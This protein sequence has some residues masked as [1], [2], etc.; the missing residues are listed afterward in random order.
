ATGD[1]VGYSITNEIYDSFGEADV[2]VTFDGDSAAERGERFLTDDFLEALSTE[3]ADDPEIDGVTGVLNEVLP[4]LN[5]EARLVEADATLIGVDPQ[6][7]DAF[8]GLRSLDGDLIAGS[9]LGGFR[10]YLSEELAEAIDAGPGDGV[11]VYYDG[12][13]TTFE[14]IGIVQN[15]SIT[16]SQGRGGLVASLDV[17]REVTG[18]EGKLSVIIV[19]IT[20][21]VRDTLDRND[22]VADRVEDFIAANPE[23]Q[24]EIFFTK[25]EAVELAELIGSIFVTFFLIFGLFAIASGIL[26]IFMIFVMLAAERR[27]EMG[28]ARAV[29]MQRLHLTESFLAEGMAYN[30]GSAAVGALLGL[31]VAFLLVL[32]LAQIFSDALGFG[33]TFNFNWQGFLVAY[34]LGVVLTFATVA[35]SSFR[36][37]NL[38]IVRAIRDLPEPQPLRGADRSIGGLFR[39]AL[40][41]LWMIGWIVVLVVSG[42]FTIL[43][44]VLSIVGVF[45]NLPLILEAIFG[46]AAL[47]AVGALMF[48]GARTVRRGQF[49]GM[50]GWRNWLIWALWVA[51]FNVVAAG[52]WLLQLSRDWAGRHRNAGGWAVI[53][54]LIGVTFVWLSGWGIDAL[55]AFQGQAF[56]YTGGFTLAVLA[57]AM[58]LVYFGVNERLSFT[59]A[60]LGLVWYWILPL[61]FSLFLELESVVGGDLDPIDGILRLL[62]LPRP[63]HIE[64]NIEMFFVS[65]IAITAAAVLVIILNAELALAP[66]R[67][68]GGLLGGIAPAIKTAIAYPV[69]S[70]FR[71]GMTLAMFGL[72]VF[73]LVVMATLN[74]NFTQAF[75]SDEASGGFD[76]AVDVNPNNRVPDLRQALR[77]AGYEPDATIGGAGRLVSAFPEVRRSDDPDG[78]D[79]YATYHLAGMNDEFIDL[80]RFPIEHRAVGY[81]SDEA[82]WEALRTDPTV[83]VVDASRL[84][85]PTD[86]GGDPNEPGNFFLGVTDHDVRHTPWDPIPLTF[87]EPASGQTIELRI[88][89]V[90][91]PQVTAVIPSFFAIFTRAAT[92]QEG[93]EGGEF[94]SYFVVTAEATDEAAIETARDI[95]STLLELGVQANSIDKLI[96]DQASTSRS[97]Q[98][99]FEGFMGLGLIVGIA[100]L[101]VIAFRTVVER[102]QQIGMLR[103]IGYSRRLVALSYFLESSF[104]ALAGIAIG[105]TLGLAIS[106]NLLASPE[107]TGG[108]EI[109]FQVP[110]ARL[111]VVLVVAYGASA[112]MTLLPARAA[113]RVAVAEALRYE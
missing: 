107:F 106:Y 59:V 3:F 22:A 77:S 47:M 32:S 74:S 8:E 79:G 49:L 55:S 53:M 5:P 85:E 51:V 31:G 54:L 2:I 35:F 100:A 16:E 109:D 69:A 67:W 38:N 86:F 111:A 60:G 50:E 75:L 71:T 37:A 95:E 10:V 26:L 4:V 112:L 110:W 101:G 80:Q 52:V 68:L 57:V 42:Y 39:S 104:I 65:G 98:Y 44:T 21:G 6:S 34:S 7:V 83:A 14:V 103:A 102:R 30:L 43:L 99:L 64:G 56:S 41:A 33:I 81:E 73:S 19:S 72:V 1:T 62:G 24:A 20:G 61:P 18:L 23:S 93:F 27:S 15:T 108:T 45:G 36:I 17:V 70:K 113:S 9:S 76:V 13:P 90:L 91:E 89:G 58:L 63:G 28:M 66:V 105:I 94:E 87:R 88:I 92:V 29:G 46:G 25:K 84:V 82:I 40:G 96:D 11:E 12:E 78:D 48:F 97:F